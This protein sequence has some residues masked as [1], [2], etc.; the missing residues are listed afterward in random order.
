MS[1]A[2][3][4]LLHA[5][6]LLGY[7]AAKRLRLLRRQHG[8]DLLMRPL[9]RRAHPLTDLGIDGPT[10]LVT[11]AARL[12]TFNA[13]GANAPFVDGAG[14]RGD[15]G[16]ENPA[17][18]LLLAVGE[19]KL[20]VEPVHTALDEGLGRA[21]AP[22]VGAVV[23]LRVAALLGEDGG[24]QDAGEESQEAKAMNRRHGAMRVR[25]T[26]APAW[27]RHPPQRIAHSRHVTELRHLHRE[28]TGPAV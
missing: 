8:K 10:H 5:G 20:R 17:D 18:L 15:P 27:R 26:P 28:N 19:V 12:L 6:P 14:T 11:A 25:D 21:D 4:A 3:L 1:A 24:G 7:E 23:G 22:A 13:G 2:P 9:A 16:Q